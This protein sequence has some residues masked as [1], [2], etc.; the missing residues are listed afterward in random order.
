[1]IL[2]SPVTNKEFVLEKQIRNY[3]L[4][5]NFRIGREKRG[6]LLHLGGRSQARLKQVTQ[7]MPLGPNRQLRIRPR[8]M[9]KPKKPCIF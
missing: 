3:I 1:M 5:Q 9:F 4:I 8:N 2:S 6:R 7:S